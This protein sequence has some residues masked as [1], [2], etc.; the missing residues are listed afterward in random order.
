MLDIK[1][2][3]AIAYPTRQFLLSFYF[4]VIFNLTAMHMEALSHI[5]YTY[6]ILSGVCVMMCPLPKGE[7]SLMNG[8][9]EYDSFLYDVYSEYYRFLVLKLYIWGADCKRNVWQ[10][11]NC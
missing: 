7:V 8:I 6:S 5:C 9:C 2:H 3:Y 11:V 10:R 4:Y 1:W